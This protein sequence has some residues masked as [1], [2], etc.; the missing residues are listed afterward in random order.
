MLLAMIKQLHRFDA[1][2]I[3]LLRIKSFFYSI[4]MKFNQKAKNLYFGFFIEI[5]QLKN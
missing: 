4:A 1:I 2:L 5:T 3:I